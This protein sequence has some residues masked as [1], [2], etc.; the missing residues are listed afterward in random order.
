MTRRTDLLG[1]GFQAQALGRVQRH[2]FSELDAVLELF[3]SLAVDRSNT[4]K[5]VELLARRLLVAVFTFA[6]CTDGAN[7]GVSLAEVVLLDLGQRNVDVVRTGEVAGRPDECV[8]LQDVQDA[9]YGE[10][11][12]VF[13]N[14]DVVNSGPCA[15]P[16]RRS[17]RS[18][19]RSLRVLPSRL[20]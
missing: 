6:W 1:V 13:G 2:E 17:L 15:R 11:D 4:N 20:S 19:K 18:R 12:V 16:R 5:G 7:D 10:Q 8:V 3:R 9:R 14:L